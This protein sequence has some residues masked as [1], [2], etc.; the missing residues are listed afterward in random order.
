LSQIQNIDNLKPLKYTDLKLNY[1]QRDYRGRTEQEDKLLQ[2]KYRRPITLIS[3]QY[4][5]IVNEIMKKGNEEGGVFNLFSAFI[6]ISE[7][8]AIFYN[9]VKAGKINEAIKLAFEHPVL[10]FKSRDPISV[11]ESLPSIL[12]K[13][14]PEFIIS[15]GRI[16][17]ERIS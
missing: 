9:D 5:Q 2:E 8:I 15:V 10:P 14:L 12:I 1:D 7:N 4:Q 16:M 11:I 17:H 6:K 13:H 3:S